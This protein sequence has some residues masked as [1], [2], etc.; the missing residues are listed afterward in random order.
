M[1]LNKIH[2][3]KCKMGF[4]AP[5]PLDNIMIDIVQIELND[6][7]VGEEKKDEEKTEEEATAPAEKVGFGANLL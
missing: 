2:G 5:P 7:E 3:K 6:T 4:S 1:I